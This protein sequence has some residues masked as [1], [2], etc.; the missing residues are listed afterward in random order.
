MCERGWWDLGEAE[1]HTAGEMACKV[2]SD[3]RTAST[4]TLQLSCLAEGM[5]S[6]ETWKLRALDGGQL[7]VSRDAA[8]PVMLTRCG[9]S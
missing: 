9:G 3:E 7:S 4:A 6:H 2:V 8:P 5:Q 1:I